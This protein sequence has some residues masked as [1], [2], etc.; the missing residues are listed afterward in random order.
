MFVDVALPLPLEGFFT[1]TVPEDMRD[2]VKTGMRAVVPLG[3]SKTYVGVV[4]EIHDR[5]PDFETRD[6][7]DLPDSKP[8][9]TDSQL[10]LWKWVADYYMSPFAEV[11]NVAMPSGLKDNSYRPKYE[12]FVSLSPQ[13]RQE[14]A[15]HVA[16]GMLQRSAQQQKLFADY[17]ALSQ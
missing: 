15:L 12:T 4:V 7:I 17:L 16:F 11:Y 13:F 10:K 9:V 3:R 6:I 8:L 14:Q 1:Y 5:K 2:A